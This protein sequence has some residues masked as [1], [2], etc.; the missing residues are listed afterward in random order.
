MKTP[1]KHD[2]DSAF[3]DLL[4]DEQQQQKQQQP[5]VK[6]YLKVLEDICTKFGVGRDGD[7]ADDTDSISSVQ[8]MSQQFTPDRDMRS[9]EEAVQ[10]QQPLFAHESLPHVPIQKKKRKSVCVYVSIPC[11]QKNKNESQMTDYQNTLSQMPNAKDSTNNCVLTQGDDHILKLLDRLQVNCISNKLTEEAELKLIKQQSQNEFD[12]YRSDSTLVWTDSDSGADSDFDA[13]AGA[14]VRENE[15]KTVHNGKESNGK[16]ISSLTPNKPKSTTQCGEVECIT[17][18][19]NVKS[20]NRNP[21]T[22]MIS[23]QRKHSIKQ[24][25]DKF[26]VDADLRDISATQ[27]LFVASQEDPY[28]EVESHAE[29]VEPLHSDVPKKEPRHNNRRP[30]IRPQYEDPCTRNDKQQQDIQRIKDGNEN[31][32]SYKKKDSTKKTL[33]PL[34]PDLRR[35]SVKKRSCQEMIAEAKWS[36]A[37]FISKIKEKELALLQT[38]PLFCFDLTPKWNKIAEIIGQSTAIFKKKKTCI[39]L[40]YAYVYVYVYVYTFFKNKNKNRRKKSTNPDVDE[41]EEEDLTKDKKR[42]ALKSGKMESLS[43]FDCLHSK[44]KKKKKKK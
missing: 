2:F 40:I 43:I 34:S 25:K 39:Y 23:S 16:H 33:F 8:R 11:T 4:L 27:Q 19:L 36:Q 6:R 42:L 1:K 32:M 13:S 22:S 24:K 35:R 31:G 37:Q 38:C 28:S 3:K 12:G 21:Q 15:C 5:F 29:D 9:D 44:K 20:D 7:N 41:S 30:H 26:A 14:Q 17:P 10:S 18:P